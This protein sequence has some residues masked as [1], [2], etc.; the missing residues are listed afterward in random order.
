MNGGQELL[1]GTRAALRGRRRRRRRRGRVHREL[2]SRARAAGQLRL[3]R[4]AHRRRRGRP[5]RAVQVGRPDRAHDL[6]HAARRRRRE[7]GLMAAQETRMVST[8][9]RDR[10]D[11]S[12]QFDVAREHNN[13]YGTLDKAFSMDP[14]AVV[15]EVKT[16]GLRGQG[17]RRLRLRPEVVARPEGRVPALPR[18]ERRR[19]RAVHVQGPH[20]RRARPA[21][22]HRGCDRQRVRDQGAPRV[23]LPARRVRARRRAARQGDRGRLLARLPRPEHPRF[24]LRPRAH[25]A[26]RRRLLHRGRRNGS[27][28][29]SRG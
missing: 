15:E 6:G 25:H 3:P 8:F 23:H 22:D 14:D 1:A 27:A 28:V 19:G 24:G 7:R 13:A 12:W 26:P 21:P 4:S 9:L 18:G 2:R 20:A 11:D 10:P 17:R 16:S 5:G 29:E